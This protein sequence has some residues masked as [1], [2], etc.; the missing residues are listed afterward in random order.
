[1]LGP[2]PGLEVMVV[3]RTMKKVRK[4]RVKGAQL[5]VLGPDQRMMGEVWWTEEG[6]TGP[7]EGWRGVR[8][9]W[10]EG[11]WR[12]VGRCLQLE[13]VGGR[14]AAAWKEDKLDPPL[15]LPAGLAVG[16]ARTDKGVGGVMVK[17]RWVARGR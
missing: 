1:M 4:R 13:L 10:L 3:E 2:L 6:W 17:S 12:G 8:T 14:A 11:R 5:Q 7:G 16:R 15:P 9:K